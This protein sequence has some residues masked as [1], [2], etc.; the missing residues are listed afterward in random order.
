MEG[1]TLG[2]G[3]AMNEGAGKSKLTNCVVGHI[4]ETKH[5]GR[6]GATRRYHWG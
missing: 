3:K 2:Q 1:T 4:S 6:G 5:Q